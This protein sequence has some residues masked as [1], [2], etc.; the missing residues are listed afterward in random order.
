MWKY[1]VHWYG[2]FTGGLCQCIKSD[3]MAKR[4]T[5]SFIEIFCSATRDRD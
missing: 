1:A 4:F 5:R 3:Q 2:D